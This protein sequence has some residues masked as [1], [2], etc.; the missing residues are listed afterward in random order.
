MT[1]LKLIAKPIH[2]KILF[3][4]SEEGK[5][6]YYYL[7]FPVR[8]SGGKNEF[9][10]FLEKCEWSDISYR[11]SDEQ[12]EGYK[13]AAIFQSFLSRQGKVC[14]CFSLSMEV[15][16]E[17][18]NWLSTNLITVASQ[19]KIPF[20]KKVEISYE[21]DFEFSKIEFFQWFNAASKEPSKKEVGLKMVKLYFNGF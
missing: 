9:H 12:L 11:K 21:I 6:G 10:N 17:Y 16:I 2:L 7:H 5:N 15:N 3:D 1:D 20:T 13:A 14:Y 19:P 18:F 8:S 4:N